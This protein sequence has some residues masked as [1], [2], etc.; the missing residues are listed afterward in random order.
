MT[1]DF[2]VQLLDGAENTRCE[3]TPWL[4][5]ID[6]ADGTLFQLD[7]YLSL[8]LACKQ[9]QPLIAVVLDEVLRTIHVESSHSNLCHIN[10]LE[11]QFIAF[12]T[13]ETALRPFTQL[14]SMLNSR[15]QA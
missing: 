12:G 4:L 2:H 5:A 11:M 10:A 8:S 9:L 13:R 7:D 15:S 14:M 6:L 3:E 1:C